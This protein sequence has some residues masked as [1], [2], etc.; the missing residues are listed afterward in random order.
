MVLLSARCRGCHKGLATR[1]R[2]SRCSGGG[3]GTGAK[4]VREAND[5]KLPCLPWPQVEVDLNNFKRN[6]NCYPHS[7]LVMSQIFMHITI[8]QLCRSGQECCKLFI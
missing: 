5:V 6:K 8:C 2:G 3:H 7:F 1:C 4:V